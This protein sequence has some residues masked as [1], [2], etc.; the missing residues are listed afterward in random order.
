M[1][2]IDSCTYCGERIK[3]DNAMKE[4]MYKGETVIHE[5]THPDKD[6]NC[7][8]TNDYFHPGCYKKKLLEELLETID[9]ET[10]IETIKLKIDQI[11]T[12]GDKMTW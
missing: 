12:P 5:N 1:K 10:L 3:W 4:I 6:N 2:G 8:K 11:N 7:I 9:D